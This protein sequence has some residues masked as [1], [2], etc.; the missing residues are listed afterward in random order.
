[1][2]DWHLAHIGDFLSRFTCKAA[3]VVEV[4]DAGK[5]DRGESSMHSA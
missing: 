2:K 5:A 4:L 1:M 3:K